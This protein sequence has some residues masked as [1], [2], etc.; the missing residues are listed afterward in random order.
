MLATESSFFSI[1]RVECSFDNE[2]MS[3]SANPYKKSTVAPDVKVDKIKSSYSLY[4]SLSSIGSPSLHSMKLFALQSLLIA[5]SVAS[6]LEGRQ[7]VVTVTKTASEA[8][9][10]PWNHGAVMSYPI[11]GS[12]NVTLR[13]QLEYG[14]G[15]MI[16][17]AVQ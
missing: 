16:K 6:P 5:L 11:H 15:D 9:A 10:T 1:E 17:L 12:C 2:L 13:A 3:T 14:L 7:A 8:A 4:P